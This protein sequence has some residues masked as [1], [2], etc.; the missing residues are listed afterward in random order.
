R[1]VTIEEVGNVAAFLLSDLSS[2]VTGEIT[3]V[4]GGYNI[5]GTAVE[6]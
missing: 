2:G 4:D 6:G 1:N 5:V 3:Y